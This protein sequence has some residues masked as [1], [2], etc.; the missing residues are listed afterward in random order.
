MLEKL[1]PAEIAE[2]LIEADTDKALEP[3]NDA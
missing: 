3:A 1:L 2:L